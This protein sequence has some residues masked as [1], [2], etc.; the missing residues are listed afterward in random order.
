[1]TTVQAFLP[2]L[3]ELPHLSNVE[4]RW[5]PGSGQQVAFEKGG[6]QFTVRLRDIER[7]NVHTFDA[8]Y[9]RGRVT[10][11]VS[12]QHLAQLMGA[13]R[14]AV[15]PEV[16]GTLPGSWVRAGGLIADEP[17]DGEAVPS[18][19]PDPHGDSGDRRNLSLLHS[20][21]DQ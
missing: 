10:V 19:V 21:H 1:M 12:A 6:R 7:P 13:L 14:Q 3:A 2:G 17:Q 8:L 5:V 20:T 4:L 9:L 16:A 11:L 15:T 18:T